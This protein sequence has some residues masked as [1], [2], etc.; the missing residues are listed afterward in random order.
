MPEGAMHAHSNSDRAQATHT[1]GR[2]ESPDRQAIPHAGEYAPCP[3]AYS[4]KV[5]GS[6]KAIAW[7]QRGAPAG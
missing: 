3:G 5:A 2:D 7:L 6:G 1:P 4:V